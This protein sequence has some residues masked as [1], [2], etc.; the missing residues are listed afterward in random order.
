MRWLSG[1]SG[2]AGPLAVIAA[3][4]VLLLMP[5]AASATELPEKITENT[6][7]TAAGNPYTG[8]SVTI[9]SGVT[10]KVEPGVKLTVTALV[11]KGTLK[12]E[13]TAESPVLFTS[14]AEKPKAGDWQGIN[15]E[16]GSGSSILDHT[17]VSYGGSATNSGAIEVKNSSPTI[18]IS[19]VRN[20]KY[21][22]IKVYGGAP[23]I[24]NNQILN[25]STIG[26]YYGTEGAES[27]G[28]NFH[29]NLLEGNAGS[30]TI[31]VNTM[32]ATVGTRLSG[33][34]ITKNNSTQAVYYSGG[35]NEVPADIA[36]NSVS[37]NTGG[38]ATNQV[39][40]SG[41]L[42]KSGTWEAPTAPL[43]IEGELKIPSGVTLTIKPGV[44]VH[45][46]SIEVVGTLKAEGE[47]SKPVVFESST[48]SNWCGN[49]KFVSGS[50]ASV[51]DHAEIYRCATATNSGAIE[52]KN[53]SPTITNSTIRGS[54]YYGIKVYG[55]APDIGGNQ[56][57]NSAGIGVYYGTEGAESQGINFHGNILEGNWGSASV[58]V[59]T[60]T[61]TVAT[62]LGDNIVTNN[63]ATQAIYYNGA[64]N[65]S[66]IPAD[67][68]SNTVFGNTGGS[69]ANQVAFAGVLNKSV[70]WETPLTAPLY[71]IG[72]LKVPAEVTLTMKPGVTL[73]GGSLEVL[74][75]LKAEGSSEAPVTFKPTS[76]GRLG[77]A[78]PSC[79]AAAPRSSTTSK[80]KRRAPRPPATRSRSKTP[81]RKSRI[82]RSAKAPAGRSKPPARAPRRSPTTSLA[83]VGRS[84]SGPPRAK[85]L[86]STSTTMWSKKPG[87]APPSSSNPARARSSPPASATTS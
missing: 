24:G 71:L 54:K 43:Y 77:A 74:G 23:D 39:A 65:N 35:K 75:T 5:S 80:S 10:V 11:V 18:T 29:S 2:H 62:S 57:L 33:N 17:E 50:G 55:G 4:A 76:E 83:A 1:S 3:L 19:T 84:I 8:S 72:R 28:I 40:F 59:S 46:G 79:P 27:Q 14:A 12:A 32:G 38:S 56:I 6:T 45:G 81:R 34:T 49:I 20:S 41:V 87:P 44:T 52:V 31:F 60:M 70:T 86:R 36:N 25:S 47:A 16:P 30:A 64:P 15:F 9:E 42:A 51:L 7:L 85:R 67:I 22:G 69:S 21:Y 78:S 58:Y 63:T 48:E 37:G 66:E 26:V 13:G 68:A 82:R 61:G 73:Y 53:S